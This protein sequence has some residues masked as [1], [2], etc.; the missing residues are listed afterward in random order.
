VVIGIRDVLERYDVD[1]LRYYLSVAGPE[2]Q[3]TDFTWS[4]FRRRNNDELADSWG[5]L[6]N[7]SVSLAARNFGAVPVAGPLTDA[8]AALLAGSKAAF[9]TVGDLIE[10]SRQKAAIGEA[11][12]V[13]GDANRYLSDQAP[14][15]LAKSEQAGD[16]ERAGT[17]LHVALQVVD[18][19]KTLLTP[20]LPTSSDAVHRLLGSPAAPGE[21]A[22]MPRVVEVDEQTAIG[23]PSYPVITGDYTGGGRWESTPLPVGRALAPPKPLFKK[24]DESIVDDELARLTS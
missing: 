4:E 12:R 11:M 23:S 16:K 3:D 20:F 6:V 10:R 22:P 9:G 2:T 21:W 7:R 8:D 14:W 5:N 13:V 18:D 1:A 17:I 24:L 15:K 19:A